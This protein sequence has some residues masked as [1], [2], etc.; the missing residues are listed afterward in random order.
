M[1]N[2][3]LIATCALAAAVLAILIVLLLQVE[4]WRRDLTTNF[5]ATD[6]K[7]ADEWLRPLRAPLAPAAL[8]DRA[9]GAMQPR[10]NWKLESRTDESN[11][12]DLHFIRTTPV[13]R[14]K[15]DIRVH[16]EPDSAGGSV[17]NAQSR[18]RVGKGD[19]GQNPR[20]L[21][22]LLASVRHAIE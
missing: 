11:R 3:T 21:R 2:I 12:I 20:N 5:A 15:D 1:H 16:I 17:L 9:I 7:S 8:A 10:A 13:M 19:L 6:E 22:E 18:S 4:N 14:F